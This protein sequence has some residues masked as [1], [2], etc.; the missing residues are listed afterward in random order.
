MSVKVIIKKQIVRYFFLSER[1]NL[2]WVCVKSSRTTR[3][4]Y[5]GVSLIIVFLFPSETELKKS[6]LCICLHIR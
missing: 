1:F 2:F 6:K 3:T 5:L 4:K